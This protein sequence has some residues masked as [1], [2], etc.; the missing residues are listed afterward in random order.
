MAGIE[1]FD[2][3]KRYINYV[4]G[5]NIP[6]PEELVLELTTRKPANCSCPEPYFIQPTSIIQ[7]INPTTLDYV[8][9]SILPY[10]QKLLVNGRGDPVLS[11]EALIKTLEF[12]K[13]FSI[14]V[15][16]HT[17]G[18]DF[19]KEIL[20]GVLNS[21]VQ[22]L[23][24]S[25]N[26]PDEKKYKKICSCSIK[27]L[28]ETLEIISERKK[29]RNQILPEIQF[30][31]VA[32]KENIGLL[33]D[34]LNL[35]YRYNASSL[36]VTPLFV[37]ND[38]K[39]NC[40]FRHHFDE[41]EEI[42]YRS[43]IEAEMKGLDLKIEPSQLLEALGSGG[44]IEQYLSGKIPPDS[45]SGE[46]IKDNSCLWNSVFVDV[47]G[48][49][50]PSKVSDT[51]LGNL[52]Q[53]SFQSIWYGEPFKTLR[54]NYVA[55]FNQTDP[56]SCHQLLWR[57]KRPLKRLITPDDPNFFLFPGWFESELEERTH[58]YTRD[59]A[60]V[61]L[62]QDET[63][64][65]VLIQMRKAPFSEAAVQGK[66]VIN[67]NTVYPFNLLTN[68]WETFEY[69]LPDKSSNEDA[70]S[71]E[72]IPEKTVRPHGLDEKSADF[73][74]LGVK[75][76]QIWL[77]SWAK[78]VVYAQKLVLLGYE[79]IPDSWER[80]GDAVFLTYWRT[81]SKTERDMKVLLDF[82]RE[83]NEE[84]DSAEKEV[85]SGSLSSVQHDFLLSHLGLPS[86]NWSEGVFISHECRIP[87][88]S[89]LTPGHYRI[90]LGIYPEG[91]PKKRAKIT[92]SDREHHENLA[93]L[94]TVMI[95]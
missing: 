26:A 19:T 30:R 55:G 17:H 90:H 10:V 7:D 15:T 63:D 40:A 27:P 53:E 86:S 71:V 45:I 59:R 42:M 2:K 82:Q 44:D 92:R 34:I 50:L 4:S 94:G 1:A 37:G 57:K 25:V 54:R 79:I 87:I 32:V 78:K 91:E 74:S 47:E 95:S 9:T 18:L 89:N 31:M 39:D 84:V 65:F 23:V 83:N 48:N 11:E 8:L 72:I 21:S 61:F 16:I 77:E 69:P 13:E 28:L 20:N 68:H 41:T 73:R 66:I 93:L 85:D 3:S 58:R 64:L 12:A 43:L 5:D 6:Y 52:E 75:V 33:T 76:S 88:P 60:T 24:F 49:I 56:F 29:T 36:I 14:P 51:S 62:Q 70:V 38:S 35:A 81:L 46:W 22:N 80:D 67:E